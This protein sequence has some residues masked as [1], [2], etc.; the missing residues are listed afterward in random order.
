MRKLA[1]HFGCVPLLMPAWHMRAL[2]A[3]FSGGVTEEGKRSPRL[4]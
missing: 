4:Q 2:G 1:S 3:Q